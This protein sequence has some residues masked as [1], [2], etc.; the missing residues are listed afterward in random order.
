[1]KYTNFVNNVENVIKNKASSL[2]TL[3]GYRLE[4]QCQFNRYENGVLKNDPIII[5]PTLTNREKDFNNIDIKTISRRFVNNIQ[6]IMLDYSADSD[7][8]ALSLNDLKSVGI[9]LVKV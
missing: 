1:M 8:Q 4:M 7:V 3:N 5:N 9:K 6:D 2:R